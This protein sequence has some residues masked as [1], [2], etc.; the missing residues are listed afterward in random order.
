MGDRIY[1]ENLIKDGMRNQPE[2]TDMPE[3]KGCICSPERRP[4]ESYEILLNW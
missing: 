2:K 3:G 4:E 1:I